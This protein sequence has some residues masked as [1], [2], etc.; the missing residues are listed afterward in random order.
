MNNRL[1]TENQTVDSSAYWATIGV[2]GLIFGVAAFFI[3]TL[4]TY[5]RIQI[6]TQG[7]FISVYFILGIIVLAWLIKA[8]GGGFACWYYD[9]K[10]GLPVMTGRAAMMGFIT[11]VAI[12]IV[13]IILG[14]IWHWI[15]PGMIHQ[16]LHSDI[17]IIKSL[18]IPADQKKQFVK[19]ITESLKGF[20][21]PGKLLFSG[22]FSNGIPNLVTG[23]IA[24]KILQKKM[25]EQSQN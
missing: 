20:R 7:H 9:K 14:S 1:E 17:A 12:T 18:D 19:S 3:K 6:G 21:N 10:S 4:L 24:A 22:I 2:T 16:K 15:A 23:M 11:G 8:C 13:T 5:L 25:N